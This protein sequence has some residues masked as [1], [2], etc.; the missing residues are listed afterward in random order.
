MREF[1]EDLLLR[2]DDQMLVGM[3]AAVSVST[4]R[5]RTRLRQSNKPFVDRD[6]RSVPTRDEIERT[7]RWVI[8]NSR[9]SSMALGGIAGALGPMSVPP[10]VMLSLL[11]AVRLAQ[12]LAVVYGF[13]PD[14]DSGRMAMWRAL[15]AGFEVDLPSEGP[16]GMRVSD[17]P[18]MIG[19]P[20]LP[21]PSTVAGTLAK[22]ALRRTFWRVAGRVTRWVPVMAIGAAANGAGGHTSTLGEEMM[23]VY[24]RL[25]ELPLARLSMVDDAVE[26]T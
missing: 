15:A 2:A 8:D 25:A 24:A 6:Q 26:V 5:E 9:V 11:R 22:R 19:T 4:S 7:A 13:D 14:S 21:D 12:R 20:S 17:I 1:F 23:A 3:Y 10:E 16:L 18:E